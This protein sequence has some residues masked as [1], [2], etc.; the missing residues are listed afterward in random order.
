MRH[1][2]QQITDG[3]G[4]V[5]GT[6][7]ADIWHD[8]KFIGV[9]STAFFNQ[10]KATQTITRWCRKQFKRM[11]V[12]APLA[13]IFYQKFMGG[14]DRMDNVVAQLGIKFSKNKKRWQRSLWMWLI[15]VTFYNSN[16]IM[17]HLF[18]DRIEEWKKKHVQFGH[19]HFMVGLLIAMSVLH[20]CLASWDESL[21]CAVRLLCSKTCR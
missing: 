4:N 19:F 21:V 8:N 11:L 13:L 6:L 18:S 7:H 15:S 20:V 10:T 9:L 1:C 12:V 3:A 16:I 14:V 2:F 17:D 5:L